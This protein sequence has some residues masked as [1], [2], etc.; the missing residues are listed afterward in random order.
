[1]R[2]A[3]Q[4]KINDTQANQPLQLIYQM[5][6]VI[7]STHSDGVAGQNNRGAQSKSE[8][9]THHKGAIPSALSQEE[10]WQ[11]TAINTP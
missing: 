2:P 1:M 3:I 11:A 6:A 10:T 5:R 7:Q 4:R 9:T 8:A